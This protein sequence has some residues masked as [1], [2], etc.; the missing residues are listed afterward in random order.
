MRVHAPV[1]SLTARAGRGVAKS[2]SRALQ[3]YQ[4]AAV[5]GHVKAREYHDKLRGLPAAVDPEEEDAMPAPSA[6]PSEQA[7][8]ATPRAESARIGAKAKK[9]KRKAGAPRTVKASV[10]GRRR[11]P[12]SRAQR[13]ATGLRIRA[14]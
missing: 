6:R 7:D 3:W 5:Q 8:V 2:R 11:S 14:T 12:D 9:G 10:R 13:S 4:R 1:R